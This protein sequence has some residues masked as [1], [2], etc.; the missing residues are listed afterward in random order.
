M[1]FNTFDYII[2]LRLL[3]RQHDFAIGAAVSF[4]EGTYMVLVFLGHGFTEL[5]DVILQQRLH[6]RRLVVRQV[7]P[8]LVEAVLARLE[9]AEYLHQFLVL[10]GLD[11][12]VVQRYQ[13]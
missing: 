5:F 3:Q 4:H 7:L 8:A 10:L 1:L 11:L 2:S 6:D 12:A 13:L 9:R